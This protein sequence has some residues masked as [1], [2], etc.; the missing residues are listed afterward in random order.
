MSGIDGHEAVQA[1]QGELE[2]RLQVLERYS[3]EQ[4]L[5]E[6]GAGELHALL[7]IALKNEVEAS[8]IAAVW[9]PTTPELFVKLGLARQVG[10]EARHYRLLAD[11]LRRN[12]DDLSGFDP[13]AAGYSPLFEALRGLETTVERLAAGQFTREAIAVQRNAM[14][15]EWLERAGHAEVAALYRDEIQPDE[16][17]HHELGVRGLERLLTDETAV[18]RARKAMEL[19]LSIADEM[20]KAASSRTGARAIPGC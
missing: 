8:E 9:M 16:G 2:E 15:I 12:G 17:H 10:D 1:L 13:L 5:A 14:F 11:Y 6:E 20:R 18:A 19:T 7:R 4:E 3:V